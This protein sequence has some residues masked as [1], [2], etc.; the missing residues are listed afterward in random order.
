MTP[1]SHAVPLQEYSAAAGAA[2]RRGDAALA[3]GCRLR[4]LLAGTAGTGHGKPMGGEEVGSG[5]WQR[6]GPRNHLWQIKSEYQETPLIEC[7]IPLKSPVRT[8][9]WP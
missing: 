5:T 4:L 9:K 6:N 7:I 8:D 1:A 3:S 2:E